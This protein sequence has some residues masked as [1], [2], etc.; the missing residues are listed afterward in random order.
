MRVVLIRRRDGSTN[1]PQDGSSGGST[2]PSFPIGSM[3]LP[4]VSVTWRDEAIDMG[5]VA[6]AMS[7]VL[8][9]AAGGAA[10]AVTV[11][12]AATFRM[13]ERTTSF[14]A[15]A[16]VV[17]NGSRLSFDAL[18]VQAPDA[19]LVASGAA[20]PLGGDPSLAV[21][22]S[23]SADLDR[24]AAW[25]VVGAGRSARS[26]FA[27]TPRAALRIPSRRSRSPQKVC[28][29]SVRW[30]DG[31]RRH[32][33]RPPRPSSER[34]WC[35]LGGRPPHAGRVVLDVGERAQAAIDWRG[36][37]VTLVLAALGKRRRS[38]PTMIDGRATASYR[39]AS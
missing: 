16:R 38:D 13:G 7:V 32:A 10:G 20:A 1:F 24:L 18:R 26:R 30:R 12:P 19:T 34:S 35:A 28:P 15:S 23:G 5:A 33:R 14:L 9:P 11:A 39:V 37:D 29:G 17:W 27:R 25:F 2:V 22:A 8:R 21:D 4:S 36:V 3:V 31:H 6:T